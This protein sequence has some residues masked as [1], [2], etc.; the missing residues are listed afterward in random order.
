[1]LKNYFKIAFRNLVRN[2]GFSIINILGLSIG[3]ASAAIILLWVQNEV[4]Y[5]R[6]HE[7]DKRLYE[8]WENDLRDGGL[9]SG[10]PTQQLL[11]PSLKK[12]YPE[13]ENTARIGWNEYVLFAYQNKSVKVNGTW[14]DP[15]FLTMFSF[16]LLKGDPKTALLDPHSIVITQSAAK[17]L[18]GND[19]P[20]GKVV[21]F[22]N[23]E[24]FTVT[25]LLK[26]LPNNTQFDF[27]YLNSSAFLETKGWIDADWTD[28]S[29]RTF[30]LLTPNAKAS[31]ANRKIKDIVKTY[32]KGLSKSTVFLYPVNQLR[33]YSKFENGKPTG[34]RIEIVQIFSLV[35]LFILIIACINF[36]NLSTAR[37]EKRAKEVGIRK[38]AGALRKSLIIQFLI[39]SVIVSFIAGC[40]AYLLIILSLPSF[41]QLTQKHLFIDNSNI[42][43]WLAG[44]G[45]ILLTGIL[46]GSYPAFFLASFK[47]AAVLKGAF[48]KVHALV[49]P[50]KI[51][52]VSQFTFAIVLIICTLVVIQQVK[53]ATERKTGYDRNNLAYIFLE[54]DIP[55]NYDNIKNELLNSGVAIS[56]NQ[57]MAPLTQSWSAGSS[58]SWPGKDPTMRISFDRSTTDG[59]LTKTLGIDFIAGRDID[60][61][62]YSTDSTAC[63]VNESAVK[64]MKFKNPI[65]QTIFDDPITWHI[66]GVIKDFIL[67]SPYEP[68]RP[69]IFKGPKYGRNVLN[70]KFNSDH[71]T[72]QNLA[73]TEKIFKKYNPSYPFEYHFI[74]E[75]YAKKFDDE[76]LTATLAGLFSGLTIFI[77]CLGLFGL[78]TY[79]AENRIKEVGVRKILGASITSIAALLSKDFLKLILVAILI[80]S[81]VAWYFMNTWLNGF[82]YRIHISWTVFALAG[83]ASVFI[84]LVTIS[85]QAIRAA[86]ANPA[87]SLRSE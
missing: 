44:L 55:K 25:G 59:N 23:Q 18:F 3:M 69:I 8:I 50:R 62:S 64:L 31:D 78:A 14:A 7:K 6:F 58:L 54:G 15:S 11:A 74:D 33:L 22:D 77:S 39:E 57:T 71:T 73:A 56:I 61:K 37:S 38:V 34:G 29:I 75:E 66:V 67:T 68:I 72:S 4:S 2:R 84:A 27:E 20:M 81:P 86:V 26:D 1:M 51:L 43:F 19:D 32:S 36:M 60:L 17:K 79:M 46:A 45:F 76:K 10:V 63:I 65:G 5:D 16:P 47:P 12:D 87:T 70:I 85:F 24:N 13:I 42:Y 40:F 28:I 80:A 35:A 41:N 82:N 83:F 49:T 30:V 9:Q 53:Y 52:V 21:K 48:K